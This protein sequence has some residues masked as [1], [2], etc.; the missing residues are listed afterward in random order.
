MQVMAVAVALYELPNLL[1]YALDLID[2]LRGD[3]VIR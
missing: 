2:S 3:L 1:E